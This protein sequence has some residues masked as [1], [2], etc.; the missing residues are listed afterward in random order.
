MVFEDDDSTVF[1]FG[2]TLINLLKTSAAEELIQPTNVA[3]REAESRFVFTIG[4][5]DIGAMCA[6]HAEWSC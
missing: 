1:K 6:D 4:V 3:R 2:N 5:D